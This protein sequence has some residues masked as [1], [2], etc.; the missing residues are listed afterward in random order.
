MLSI[1]IILNIITILIVA[2][3]IGLFLGLYDRA[4]KSKPDIKASE[5]L[6]DTLKDPLVVSRAYFTEP[7][8]GPIGDFTGMESSW[9]E[10]NRLH[11]FS[12]KES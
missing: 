4:Q 6:R 9:S 8:T 2:L 1:S 10:D 12:H 7:T 11:G 3:A 5:V